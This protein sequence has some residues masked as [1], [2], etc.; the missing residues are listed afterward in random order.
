MNKSILKNKYSSYM[1]QSFVRRNITVYIVFLIIPLFIYF[2][3]VFWYEYRDTK[4]NLFQGLRFISQHISY[5]FEQSIKLEQDRL[6]QVTH[7]LSLM[8]GLGAQDALER[9]KNDQLLIF[10]EIDSRLICIASSNINYINKDFSTFDSSILTKTCR[11]G[12]FF[13]KDYLICMKPISSKEYLAVALP[14][15]PFFQ[16]ITSMIKMPFP[17]DSYLI[18]A[19]NKIYAC[20]RLFCLTTKNPPSKGNTLECKGRILK[21]IKDVPKERNGYEF[22]IVKNKKFS[23]MVPIQNSSFSLVSATHKRHFYQGCQSNFVRI[24]TFFVVILIIGGC[25]VLLLTYRFAK[26]LQQL[27]FVMRR[28]SQGDLQ[29]RYEPDRLGFEINSLGKMFNEAMASL[30]HFIQK[31]SYLNTQ[32]EVMHKELLLGREVQRAILPKESPHFAHLDIAFRFFSAKEVGGDFYDVI[33]LSDQKIMFLIGDTVGKG[34]FACFYSLVLRSIIRSFTT[35]DFSL[36]E[37]IKRSNSLFLED[38][39]ETAIFVTLW[40]GIYDAKS[41]ILTYTCCGH[42]PSLLKKRDGTIEKLETE[43]MALGIKYLNEISCKSIKLQLEDTILLYTDGIVEAYNVKRNEYYTVNRL[44]ELL[45]NRNR[46]SSQSLIDDIFSELFL[47][48]EKKALNDDAA[49]LA[50]TVN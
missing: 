3:F 48:S 8:K 35:Q 10:E 45:Q 37:I 46:E 39:E 20:S 29:A 27:Y 33:T 25:L 23:I 50:V 14:L 17:L 41:H 21:N 26:P 40:A 22:I 28:A 36:S 24:G 2:V 34:M 19:K 49:L 12:F 16:E 1:L 31:S 13:T 6:E 42:H 9:M 5:A 7:K 38:T 18:G 11:N 47:F 32:K 43:G 4:R 15:D 44:I 30:H